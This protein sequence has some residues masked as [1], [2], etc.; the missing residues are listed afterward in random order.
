MKTK[1]LSY[2][3]TFYS[4]IG[5]ILI[6]IYLALTSC[7][8]SKIPYKQAKKEWTC[9]PKKEYKP[10]KVRGHEKATPAHRTNGAFQLHWALVCPS[11]TGLRYTQS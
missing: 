10:K 11:S 2:Q 7:A 1:R 9:P 8:A 6:I 5:I 3:I 4:W